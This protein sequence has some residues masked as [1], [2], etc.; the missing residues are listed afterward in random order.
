MIE[1]KNL[2]TGLAL[3][4]IVLLIIFF[5]AYFSFTSGAATNPEGE[6]LGEKFYFSGPDPYYHGRIIQEIAETGRHP[7]WLR[8]EEGR[9]PLLSY[10]LRMINPRPPL[11]DWSIAGFSKLLLP[12]AGNEIDAIGYAMQFTPCIWGALLVIPV[13]LISVELFRDRRIGLLAALLVA[14]IPIHLVSGH[15]SA[16]ALTD[17]D[18]FVLFLS[19]LAFCFFLKAL[20]SLKSKE[21]VKNWKSGKSIVDG[22]KECFGANSVSFIYASLAGLA[23]GAIGLAWKGFQLSLV[24]LAVYLFA[25]MVI[26]KCRRKDSTSTFFAGIILF[27]PALLVPLPY[28]LIQNTMGEILLCASMLLVLTVVALFLIPTKRVPAILVLPILAGVAAIALACL[29]VIKTF[30]SG[31]PAL[32]PLVGIADT[33]FGGLPYVQK[34]KVYL[35]IQEA[36]PP[37][38]SRMVMGFGPI[39]FWLPF[40]GI[41]LL[42]VR[43]V[44]KWKPEILFVLSWVGIDLFLSTTSAR[45]LNNIIPMFAILAAWVLFTIVKK[46][47]FKG[48]V[49]TVKSKGGFK[50][51][52]KGV[53]VRHLL[54][55]ALLVGVFFPNI[56][57]AIDAAVPPEI[58]GKFGS[59]G[60]YR[61]G[62]YDEQYWTDALSWLAKQDKDIPNPEDRPGFIAWWDYGFYEIL[63]GEHP[64]VAD[65][66]QSGIEAAANFHISTDEVQAT[67]VLVTRILEGHLRYEG[68]S[69][70]VANILQNYLGQS[71]ADALIDVLQNPTHAKSFDKPIGEEYDK[72]LSEEYR[73]R[74]ENAKYHDAIDLLSSIGDEPLTQLY[75]GLQKATGYSIRYYGV[76]VK[77]F[78]SFFDIFTFLADKSIYSL[79]LVEDDYVHITRVINE[80][81]QEAIR[82]YYGMK[83][84]E[85]KEM[86]EKARGE[87]L[88]E[89]EAEELMKNIMWTP[90]KAHKPNFYNSIL[91]RTYLGE[92]QYIWRDPPHSSALIGLIAPQIPTYGLK[93]W[94]MAYPTSIDP[95]SKKGE[96]TPVVIAKYYEG[97]FI[98]GTV[99]LDKNPFGGAEAWVIDGNGIPHDHAT[100]DSRG[101]FSLIAPPGNVSVIIIKEGQ[102]IARKTF[103]KSGE[104]APISEAEARR[105]T[106]DFDRSI[107]FN[108]A[109]SQLDLIVPSEAGVEDTA[110]PL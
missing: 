87:P 37:E 102:E 2:L 39:L 19:A 78:L 46:V 107:G 75:W 10:P 9:D 82:F 66:F 1:K 44:K 101:R 96:L 53:K 13:Y 103:D 29:W 11:F 97:A 34:T 49:K 64:T 31:V 14:L 93:H 35:T 48:M 69:E 68:L 62:F 74:A 57:M 63:I 16:Y 12:I 54:V 27:I 20:K 89:T 51:L 60:A 15:G 88:N 94:V 108:I 5:T 50:G 32:S 56:Y 79:T 59:E 26:D 105:L 104:L 70:E 6:T 41:G 100:V 58:E 86:Y 8:T 92:P 98:N 81:N 30:F 84:E 38:L 110:P 109:K 45:F 22:I 28:Y 7:Y 85:E 33:L 21:W 76:N 47:N 71:K 61:A 72:N 18:S 24:I 43:L 55:I 91:Y 4:G 106:S 52:K 23:I 65:N 90:I 83:F 25:Q 40:V 95:Y 3:L 67:A 73:V 42:L 17:H 80:W 36:S 99:K 77:D